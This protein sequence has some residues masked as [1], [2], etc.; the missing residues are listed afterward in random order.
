M[1]EKTLPV[2]GKVWNFS[3]MEIWSKHREKYWRPEILTGQPGKLLSGFW[4]FDEKK[5]WKKPTVS[6][7]DEKQFRKFKKPKILNGGRFFDAKAKLCGWAEVK[8]NKMDIQSKVRRA[9]LY[10]D[11][12]RY[13]QGRRSRGK[14]L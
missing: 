1:L 14:L 8:Y 9:A 5:L 6:K 10:K 3:R 12:S 11:R 4:L 13:Y 7:I 2:D